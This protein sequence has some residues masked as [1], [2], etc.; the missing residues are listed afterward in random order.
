MKLGRAL[1]L[2]ALCPLLPGC[3]YFDLGRPHTFFRYS[4]R[5]VLL[6]PVDGT[7]EFMRV[8]RNQELAWAAW[9][10]VSKEEPDH[11]YS[12]DYRQGFY[13]G[14]TDYLT[15][16]G[17]GD[18]P[19]APPH[20]YRTPHYETPEGRQAVRDWFA[21]FRHGAANACAS[22]QRQPIVL[23]LGRPPLPSTDPGAMRSANR[24]ADSLVLPNPPEDLPPP[25]MLPVDENG[26]P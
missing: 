5:N 16:G 1:I 9:R 8:Q 23:P 21:G 2:I 19:P 18:A 4:L 17:S 15:F 20:Y 3:S 12:I 11:A 25:R 13:D 7:H 6:A 10:E 24:R 14:Y 26:R 22:G